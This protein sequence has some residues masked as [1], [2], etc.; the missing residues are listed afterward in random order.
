MVTK[1][2]T[3]VTRAAYSSS[4]TFFLHQMPCFWPRVS[5]KLSYS[6]LRV[7]INCLV[8]DLESAST[9]LFLTQSQR[10]LPYFWLSIS[11]NC[12][13]FWRESTKKKYCNLNILM[14]NSW[15]ESRN[16]QTYVRMDVW[17]TCTHMYI[18]AHSHTWGNTHAR[19]IYI[20][21]YIY[22]YMSKLTYMY[23]LQT[24]MN[25]T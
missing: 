13:N 21:I 10:Q 2:F 19:S 25:S 1:I 14:K 22:I 8:F 3:W 18:H 6:W 7:S 5:V 20:Y 4:A 12:F 11:K 16:M 9:S 23:N 24:Y 17:I 15:I